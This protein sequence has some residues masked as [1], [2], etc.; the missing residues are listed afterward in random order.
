M[1]ASPGAASAPRA[2]V[3]A[4]PSGV[5]KGTLIA[6]LREQH[7][8]LFDVSVSHTTRAPRENERDGVHYYFTTKERMQREID[9]GGFVE[10]AHVHGNMYGTSVAAVEAVARRGCVCVLDI[11]VQGCRS[12]RAAG[13]P[14]LMVFVAPPSMGELERRLRGR[15]TESEQAVT[16]RME[17]ARVEM[18]AKD[19]RGLFDA[20]IVNDALEAAYDKLHALLDG[21]IAAAAATA[22][23]AVGAS[24][25]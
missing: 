5:G 19:E 13:L 21:D 15:G 3:V 17:T 22:A 1:P 20:V 18:V 14:A 10:Y 25:R 9:R 11:D 2:L 6:K 8:T 16:K 12:V 23:T 7:P 4:G 24:S